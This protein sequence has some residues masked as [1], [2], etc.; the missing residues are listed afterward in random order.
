MNV[1]NNC[2]L[3]EQ[4]NSVTEQNSDLLQLGG[5]HGETECEAKVP[6]RV[7]LSHRQHGL[8]CAAAFHHL[9]PVTETDGETT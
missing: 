1:R 6:D 3:Q 5:H 4:Q 9:L 8:P 2:P 7:R